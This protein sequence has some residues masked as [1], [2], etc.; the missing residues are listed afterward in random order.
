MDRAI[1]RAMASIA[2]V[3]F[4]S[5]ATMEKASTSEDRRYCTGI[6]AGEGVVIV[7][8]TFLSKDKPIES[9]G[10]EKS[11]GSCVKTAM[12]DMN[13]NL[14]VVSAKDF[15]QMFFPDKK[16]LDSPRSSE[17][18]LG[19]LSNPDAQSRVLQLGVRYLV[20]LSAIT[21]ESE[22]FWVHNVGDGYA[23]RSKRWTRTSKM[24]ADILDVK[25][26]RKSGT[27]TSLSEG[28]GNWGMIAGGV[29]QCG[30][31]CAVPYCK[32]PR[33]ET[34]ACSALG[35]ALMKFLIDGHDMLL[36]P[37]LGT[38]IDSE[39]RKPDTQTE[40]QPESEDDLLRRTQEPGRYDNDSQ[41]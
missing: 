2:L 7:L 11:L 38:G 9:E 16:F 40:P 17:D 25:Y 39:G 31:L 27:V 18:L 35:E 12:A 28:E 37:E 36:T 26:L 22:R 19:V 33:T 23:D 3:L 24:T 10:E 41:N 8:N 15:R 5:C 34:E 29:P 4:C 21:H 32:F 6:N 13:P 1:W 30:I 14:K 20:V